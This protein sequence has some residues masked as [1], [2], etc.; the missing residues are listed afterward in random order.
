MILFA[1]M[2]FHSLYQ[3]WKEWCKI[4]FSNYPFLSKQIKWFLKTI[5]II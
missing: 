2:K 4:I 5:K 3:R 1:M